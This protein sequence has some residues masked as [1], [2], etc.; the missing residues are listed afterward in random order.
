[1]TAPVT[2]TAP[3]A[4]DALTRRVVQS[5]LRGAALAVLLSTVPLLLRLAAVSDRNDRFSWY[6]AAP[7]ASML[8]IVLVLVATAGSLPNRLD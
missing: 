4:G 1:M 6:L 5:A 8:V 3:T 2:P 7:V